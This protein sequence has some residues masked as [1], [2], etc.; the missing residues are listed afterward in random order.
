MSW[1]HGSFH[2]NELLTRDPEKAKKFYGGTIGWTFGGMP[3]PDGT[4]TNGLKD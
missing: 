4:Y 2:W 3:M 1:T